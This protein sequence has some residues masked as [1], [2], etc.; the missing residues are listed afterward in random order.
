M[1]KQKEELFCTFQFHT[2][3]LLQHCSST[4]LEDVKFCLCAVLGGS[5]SLFECY[6]CISYQR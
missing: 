2:T 4:A 5:P 1:D 3:A 6:E